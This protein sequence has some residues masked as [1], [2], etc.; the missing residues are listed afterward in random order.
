MREGKATDAVLEFLRTTRVGCVDVGRVPLEDR[1][2]D[3]RG[4]E[5]GPGPPQNVSFFCLAEMDGVS[6]FPL[7]FPFVGK[8]GSSMTG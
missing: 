7:S 6:S 5:G 2:E 8:R 4:E 3:E 1:G